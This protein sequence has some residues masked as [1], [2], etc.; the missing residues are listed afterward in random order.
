MEYLGF[1]KMKKW[2]QRQAM[3]PFTFY[4][5]MV[6]L[7]APPYFVHAPPYRRRK[8]IFALSSFLILQAHPLFPFFLIVD[9]FFLV[10]IT[11]VVSN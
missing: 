7:P 1:D 10:P 5:L 2:T 8:G 6:L 9:T 4:K 3:G 11:F